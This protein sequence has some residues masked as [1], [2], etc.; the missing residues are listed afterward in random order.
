[1]KNIAIVG[2]GRIADLHAPGYH[3]SGGARIYAV[4]DTNSALLKERQTEW[5][6]EKAYS[7]YTELLADPALDAVEI[8]TPQLLHEEMVIQAA[9]AGK[10]IALQKPMTVDLRSA[11]RMLKEVNKAGITFKVTENYVFYPPIV[12]ARALIEE[13]AIGQ[14]LSLRI[15]YI[16]GSGGGWSVPAAAWEWRLKEARAGRGM[17]T[18]D[19]G[20][21]LW[22]TAWYLLGEVE[23][24]QAWMDSL[25][26]LSESPTMVMW[27]YK[28]EHCLGMCDIVQADNLDIPSQYYANDEWIEITGSAGI[29]LIRRCTGE[30]VTGP[31]L[32]L[33]SSRGWQHMDMPSDWAL[34]FQGATHNF[35]DALHGKADVLLSGEQARSILRF[36]L[37]LRQS[38]NRN[39]SVFPA[40]LDRSWPLRFRARKRSW[41]EKRTRWKFWQRESTG[42]Y[43]DQADALTLQLLE[44]FDAVQAGHWKTCIALELTAEDGGPSRVY[45]LYVEN[46]QARLERE[47]AEH[48]VLKVTLPAGLWACILLKKRRI[49]TAALSGK[50]KIQGKAE[51]GLR[52]KSIFRI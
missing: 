4:C 16:G 12:R 50:L 27:R 24:V 7:S 44:R 15:R 40:E 21:H 51:E 30:V 46:G 48:A 13:G 38:A 47:L 31:V 33:F 8:L 39:R 18:F 42:A 32:S 9:R 19:H 29:L 26:G 37:A 3:G 11:D 6:A 52:L 23:E 10:H 41:P 28:K 5:Q 49:E 25:D 22:S 17:I 1:M 35:I 2:C 20:H 36:A 43:A 34:G 14:P 45:S